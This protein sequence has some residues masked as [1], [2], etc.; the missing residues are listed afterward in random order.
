M[1][2]AGGHAAFLGHVRPGTPWLAAL[3]DRADPIVVRS[4]PHINR[5]TFENVRPQALS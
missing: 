3:F 4:G 2:R 1:L 5:R